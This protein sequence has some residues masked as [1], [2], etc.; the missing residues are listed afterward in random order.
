MP[1]KPRLPLSGMDGNA[2]YILG[3]ARKVARK[4]GW[5]DAQIEEFTQKAKSGDYDNLLQVC[6]EFFDVR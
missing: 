2:F 5:T 3:T 4:A 6:E 1:S